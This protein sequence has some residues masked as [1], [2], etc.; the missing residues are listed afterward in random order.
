MLREQLYNLEGKRRSA[1]VN[2]DRTEYSRIESEMATLAEDYPSLKFPQSDALRYVQRAHIPKDIILAVSQ[3]NPDT[4][5][6]PVHVLVEDCRSF[7]SEELQVDLAD[8]DVVRSKSHYSNHEGVA[9]SCRNTEHLVLLPP[10]G[11]GFESPDLLVHEFGHTAEFNLRRSLNDDSLLIHHRLLSETV[12]HYCQY[13]YLLK[14]GTREERLGAMGSVTKEYLAL[15]AVLLSMKL[16]HDT[17]QISEVC[18]HEDLLDFTEVYGREK[19]ADILS[20]YAQLSLA[21]IYHYYVE[22]RFGAFLALRLIKQPEAVRGLALANPEKPV[23][24]ILEEDLDLEADCL[25]DFKNVEDL[26]WNFVEA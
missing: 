18:E 20:G 13:R 8:V 26:I 12:A 14:F 9:I 4:L 11:G 16:E 7:V 23:P 22:P 2:G 1:I 24:S 5:Q 19:V 10:V 21:V 6:R 17:L 15:K 25:M 3:C